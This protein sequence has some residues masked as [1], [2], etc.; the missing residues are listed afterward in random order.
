[1]ANNII[2]K[3]NG[4][5][6]N[7]KLSIAIIVLAALFVLI[8]AYITVNPTSTNTVS[9]ERMSFNVSSGQYE[10]SEYIK[11]IKTIPYYERHDDE[12]VK[13]MESLGNKQVYLGNDSIVIM[14]SSDANKIPPTPGI[15]D[16]YIYN[17]FTAEVIENHSLGSGYPT[18]YYV[19]NI[20]YTNQ[21][22]VDTG[23]A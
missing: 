12:T 4:V 10:L 18:A 6:M 7:K 20:N 11:D 21:E 22:I 8:V 23:L 5:N 19:K 15:T 17:H 1:M 16:V 14:D 13:W 3:L 9:G 2:L